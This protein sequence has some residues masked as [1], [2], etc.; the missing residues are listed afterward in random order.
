MKRTSLWA[1]TLVLAMC[2]GQ[3][4]PGCK[5]D[6]R[7]RSSEEET[8][9]TSEEKKE[10]LTKFQ[11]IMTKIVAERERRSSEV[12]NKIRSGYSVSNSGEYV[13]TGAYM[14]YRPEL[15]RLYEEDE[16][17]QDYVDQYLDDK[18]DGL[19]VKSFNF[20]NGGFKAFIASELG[21]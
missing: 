21:S 13:V 6:R 16:L 5:R 4:L 19:E 18:T 14:K 20:M 12:M 11:A 3:L 1:A 2:M 10:T 7:E 8:D 9:Y 17:F 15:L